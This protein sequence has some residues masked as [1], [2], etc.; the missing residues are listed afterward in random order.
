MKDAFAI[1]TLSPGS[2][3]TKVA[4]FKNDEQI[5]KSNVRHD[6][7]E[8]ERFDQAK[9]QLGYRVAA[10]M[11]ELDENGIELSDID[12]F[13]GY[14]GGM[15]PTI[16][17]IFAIDETVCDHVLNGGFNHP[18]ILGAPILYKFA[19]QVG[20]PAYAVNQPDTDE[21]M[22]VARI[23]GFPGVYRKSHVH[24][25]NQ[26]ECAMRYALEIGRDYD[27]V[28]VIVAHVGG[29]LSVA[30]HN[31]GRMIDTNDVLEGSGPFAPNRSGDVPLMPIVRLCYDGIHR[32]AGVEDVIGK[33]GGL[34]GLLGTDDALQIDRRIA[35]GDE[36]ARLVFDA[37][38]YQV[39]KAIGG[40]AAA[41]AGNV[42]GIVLTG[43]VSNDEYFTSSIERHVGWIAPIRVYG[44]DF[45][46]EA[47]AAGALRA[48]SGAEVVMRYSG[49]PSWTGFAMAG[50]IA[51]IG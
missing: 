13:S 33:T 51:A 46:M 25:L 49:E 22:D 2:T 15:G 27:D 41:L 36:W 4:V 39:S 5:F 34:K 21:L 42:D 50:A 26:K 43:G 10:I 31:H 38:A 40:F 23:T 12:A 44:G 18:A 8:L 35:E 16:G 32:M 1:L 6:P 45:E 20:K 3:S 9:E 48:L 24:C 30:A 14:C 37:M 7:G 29:G 28:N 11:G 17:G 19:Q 47:L